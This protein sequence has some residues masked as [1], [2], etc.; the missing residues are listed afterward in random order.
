MRTAEYGRPRETSAWG[1][2]FD[3]NQYLEK[4]PDGTIDNYAMT[5]GEYAFSVLDEYGY[6]ED[7]G[8][9]VGR[10]TES[11]KALLDWASFMPHDRPFPDPK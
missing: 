4:R 9:R 2:G 1:T 7:S 11:G 10:W 6:L 8:I 5:A 3:V